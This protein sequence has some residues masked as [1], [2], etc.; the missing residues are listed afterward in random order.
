MTGRGITAS[1]EMRAVLR[2]T[3]EADVVTTSAAVA[4]AQA[5]WLA[6]KAHLAELEAAEQ[7]ESALRWVALMAPWTV[8]TRFPIRPLPIPRQQSR[9]E[10]AY[11]RHIRSAYRSAIPRRAP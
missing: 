1:Q 8:S 11:D 10:D 4:T 5:E 3:A 2:V 9:T 7:Y 6:A